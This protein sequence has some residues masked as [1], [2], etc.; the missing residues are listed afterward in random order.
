M[1]RRARVL[2]AALVPAAAWGAWLA[3]DRHAEVPKSKAQAVSEIDADLRRLTSR[4]FAGA[5]L[6]V[7][8][9]AVI[10]NSGYGLA[11][12]SSR[13][14]VAVETGFDIGSLVKPFTAV[15]ILKLESAGKLRRSDTIARFFPSAPPDKAAITVQQLLTHSSGLP[16]IVDS[17]SMPV[18]YTPDFDYELVSREEI[19][20]RA[21]NAPL[22]FA[23][24]DKSDYSNL[25]FSLLGV[26]VEVASGEPY[27]QYVR[28]A[29]FEPAGMSRT[30][31]TGPGWKPDELA[32]GYDGDDAWGT[33]LDHRWLADG[34]SWNLRSNGGMIST[35][36]DLYKWIVALGGDRL[37]S[38]AEKKTF[39]ALNTHVNKRGARTMGVAGSNGIFDACY[40]WYPDEHRLLVVLTSSNR[41]RAEKMVPDLAQVMRSIRTEAGPD[42][43][44]ESHRSDAAEPPP[45]SPR[46]VP[47]VG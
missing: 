32:V 40:L 17:R 10:L 2:L 8:D 1:S 23:P 14:A 24:G 39:F 35:A 41:F 7:H 29:V 3:L 36:E 44:Q 27:E 43:G 38:P 20:R 25:G 16:D 34:P 4:G 22:A 45:A 11:N 26:I 5:V 46:G 21:M 30:G 37:L 6:L 19:V 42:V 47:A 31:Y 28:E 12:R 9:G 33:P 18:G 13:R 15:A